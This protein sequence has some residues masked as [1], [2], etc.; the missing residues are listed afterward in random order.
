MNILSP[1]CGASVAATLA[2]TTDGFESIIEGFYFQFL[3]PQ[4]S[5]K[6]RVPAFCRSS[7]TTATRSRREIIRRQIE[8]RYLITFGL[9][10]LTI[11]L[12]NPGTTAAQQASSAS[13]VQNRDHQD[14]DRHDGDRDRDR[15]YDRGRVPDGSYRETCQDT[16]IDG[17]TLSARCQKR[18]NDWRNTSLRHFDQC[19][20]EITN[21]NGRLQCR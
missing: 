21:V 15:R 10:V 5:S 14:Q 17:D 3:Q 18:N 11:T 20:G 1:D 6:S 19:R 4:R 8:M 9:V 2:S 12:W 16:R 7:P 13:Y